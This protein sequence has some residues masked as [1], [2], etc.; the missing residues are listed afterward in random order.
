VFILIL[1][2]KDNVSETKEHAKKP[3]TINK[4][5]YLFFI[6]TKH[7]ANVV[8]SGVKLSPGPRFHT[9]LQEHIFIQPLMSKKKRLKYR[10]C[11]CEFYCVRHRFYNNSVL[12][13]S[14]TIVL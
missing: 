13:Y 3:N 14:K 8:L 1:S 12:L 5:A 9:K 6:F 2:I 10:G 7:C 4:N 11:N